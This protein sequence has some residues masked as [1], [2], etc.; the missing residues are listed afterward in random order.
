M[1]GRKEGRTDRW[2]DERTNELMDERI[3]PTMATKI[4]CRSNLCAVRRRLLT[5]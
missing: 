4:S 5:F 1:G 3:Q 2:T